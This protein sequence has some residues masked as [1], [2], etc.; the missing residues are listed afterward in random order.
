MYL[1]QTH[2]NKP[3]WSTK[4]VLNKVKKIWH[5]QMKFYRPRSYVKYTNY[6]RKNRRK[7]KQF[8]LR[9]AQ[10][11]KNTVTSHVRLQRKPD[12]SGRGTI[13][14]DNKALTYY[15]PTAIRSINTARG[16]KKEID[17]R[18]FI[19]LIFVEKKS[20]STL[21]AVVQDPCY[22]SMLNIQQLIH[23]TG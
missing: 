19:Y 5:E 6:S 21:C 23:C 1:H 15:I 20:G 22:F 2:I 10:L 17:Y 12:L 11:G 18:P 9:K 16:K 4:T 13:Y 7:K 3:Q 8:N 14:T